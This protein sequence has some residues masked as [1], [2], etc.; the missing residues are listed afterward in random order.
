MSFFP[1]CV[2]CSLT[3]KELLYFVRQLENYAASFKEYKCL[4]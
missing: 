2:T 3:N 1:E 4:M